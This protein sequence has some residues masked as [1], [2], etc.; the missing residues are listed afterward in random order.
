MI[1]NVVTPSFAE[2]LK[3]LLR[4]EPIHLTHAAR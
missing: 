1:C 4:V 2:D 3:C